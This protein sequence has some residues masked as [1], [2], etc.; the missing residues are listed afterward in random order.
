MHHKGFVVFIFY[1]LLHYKGTVA[2]SSINAHTLC[3]CALR[4]TS[5]KICK[6]SSYL[7]NEPNFVVGL[8]VLTN[9]TDAFSLI[10]CGAVLLFITIDNETIL[11]WHLF[12]ANQS[13]IQTSHVPAYLH[14]S[15]NEKNVV[16]LACATMY[17][18]QKELC[19]FDVL[20]SQKGEQWSKKFLFFL[21]FLFA[22]MNE[23]V[24][25]LTFSIV[26]VCCGGA[27]L[28]LVC[29]SGTLN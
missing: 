12:S 16:R 7:K 4:P 2:Q 6:G 11:T 15:N 24:K 1:F 9:L 21:F 8:N 14:F 13:Q 19:T 20:S 25:R 22:L 10:L 17:D 5:Q 3:A 28:F 23:R 18:V 27:L 26:K 29:C